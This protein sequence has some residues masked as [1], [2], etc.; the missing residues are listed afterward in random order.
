MDSRQRLDACD[1]GVGMDE[2]VINVP[3]QFAFFGLGQ[4]SVT[5]NPR[6]YSATGA[7]HVN[8]LSR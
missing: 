5:G 6:G 1:P 7:S 3:M 4:T 8:I 2:Q